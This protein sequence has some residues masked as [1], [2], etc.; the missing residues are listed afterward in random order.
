M[1]IHTPYPALDLVSLLS[2]QRKLSRPTAVEIQLSLTIAFLHGAQTQRGTDI[3]VRDSNFS[4]PKCKF[5]DPECK[6][7]FSKNKHVR[8]RGSDRTTQRCPGLGPRAPTFERLEFLKISKD[9]R[10]IATAI[11][12]NRQEYSIRGMFFFNL[13]PI[14][15]R[16]RD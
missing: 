12:K 13:N 7:F 6:T 11:L 14:Y 1:F 3:L 5:K 2:T 9:Y 15:T 16:S 8:E 10:I 4:H